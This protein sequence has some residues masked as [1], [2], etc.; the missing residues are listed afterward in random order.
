MTMGTL[1]GP[2]S[3]S[4]NIMSDFYDEWE[5]RALESNWILEQLEDESEPLWG[6]F[7]DRLL[8]LAE[9]LESSVPGARALYLEF[10]EELLE[11]LVERLRGGAL[12]QILFTFQPTLDPDR[13]P[14]EQIDQN[15][16]QRLLLQFFI[17]T[18]QDDQAGG[19]TVLDLADELFGPLAVLPDDPRDAAA[20]SEDLESR[21]EKAENRLQEW[22][23]LF[24]EIFY[25][26][27]DDD[28][29]ELGAI[30]EDGKDGN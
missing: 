23:S 13:T 8:E 7:S 28:L 20:P 14:E 12:D 24:I 16:L 19:A 6:K 2:M 4:S 17:A 15:L 1:P 5:V 21:R 29:P 30:E 11:Q 18:L 3:F 27:E 25:S 10:E 22:E 9:A 26:G